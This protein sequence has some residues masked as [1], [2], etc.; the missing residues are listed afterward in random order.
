M[1]VYYQIFETC[2]T[3]YKENDINRVDPSTICKTVFLT[4]MQGVQETYG[5]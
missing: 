4:S 2:D 5:G 1:H 3:L